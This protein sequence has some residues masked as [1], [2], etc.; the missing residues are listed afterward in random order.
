MSKQKDAL[1]KGIRAL[2]NS[3][4][5][6]EASPVAKESTVIGSS[7]GGI[8]TIPLDQIEVNPFQ[9]RVNFDE[10]SLQELASS[11]RVS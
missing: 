6:E 8:Q 2:L 10:D 1:G 5:N 9:P 11:I 3:M 7:T 4:D